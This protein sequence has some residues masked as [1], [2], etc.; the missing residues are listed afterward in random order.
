MSPLQFLCN[1]SQDSDF[2]YVTFW[3]LPLVD[4]VWAPDIMTQ[5]WLKSIYCKWKQ[6]YK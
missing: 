1:E 6:D 4:A 3:R 5:V 2:R